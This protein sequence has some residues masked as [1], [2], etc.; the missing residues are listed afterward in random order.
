MGAL[1]SDGVPQRVVDA[2]EFDGGWLT[3]AGVALEVGVSDEHA[4]RALYHLRKR[5]LVKNRFI[6]LR[7]GAERAGRWESRTEWKTT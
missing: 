3:V 5:G 2:L 6:T 4:R 7:A 1:K